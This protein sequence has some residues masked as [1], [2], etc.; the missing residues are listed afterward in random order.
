M[1]QTTRA[2]M[3]DPLY[4]IVLHLDQAERY[5]QQWIERN[6]ITRYQISGRRLS[7]YS[8]YDLDR[9]RV[10]W[11]ANWHNLSVWDNWHRRL[12]YI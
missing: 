11:S 8:E 12:I 5:F 2:H 7:L 1:H 4:I 10:T 9:F 3:G 6:Q